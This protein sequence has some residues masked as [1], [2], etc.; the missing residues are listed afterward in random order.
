MSG[1]DAWDDEGEWEANMADVAE[2]LRISEEEAP[3]ESEAHAVPRNE[4][5]AKAPNVKI[6]PK[7]V[8]P[9]PMAAAKESGKEQVK[10]AAILARAPDDGGSTAMRHKKKELPTIR[11]TDDEIDSAI[12]SCL[13]THRNRM[14]LLEI[15]NELLKFV[16]SY[17]VEIVS[18]PVHNSYWRLVHFRVADRFRLGHS[19]LEDDSGA[20]IFFKTDECSLPRT[21]LMD[22]D[23]ETLHR[24]Y[25][26]GDA[27]TDRAVDVQGDNGGNGGGGNRGDGGGG[28]G[29]KKVVVLQRKPEDQQQQQQGTRGAGARGRAVNVA[30]ASASA[31]ASAAASAGVVGVSN[32]KGVLAGRGGG[33]NRQGGGGRGK[34][35]KAGGRGPGGASS[36]GMP[37]GGEGDGDGDAKGK[38][39][40]YAA[41]RA[42]IF[43]EAG[44]A[45]GST[46]TSGGNTSTARTSGGN[47]GGRGPPAI[48]SVFNAAPGSR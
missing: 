46:S 9:P 17:E 16:Q 10:S 42:R 45:G 15:E 47:V 2:K 1:R 41:A 40:A 32:N 13:D 5:A 7:P 35:A 39:K 37:G 23:L 25:C 29:G 38:E 6:I 24:Q 26:Y 11:Q 31:S 21:L 14:Q 44:A 12:M 20:I 22:M 3:S 19:F 48:A 8:A 4:V 43:A 33:G 27:Y 30:S 36:S 34:G 18:P 28:G